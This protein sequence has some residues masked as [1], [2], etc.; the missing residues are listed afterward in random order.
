M[1]NIY[2]HRVSYGKDST[3][4][5]DREYRYGNSPVGNKQEWIKYAKENGYDG[6]WFTE[7]DGNSILLSTKED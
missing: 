2:V 5:E 4:P 1:S 7:K 3:P 6:I